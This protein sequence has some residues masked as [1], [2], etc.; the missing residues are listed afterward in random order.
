MR[1]L[2]RLQPPHAARVSGEQ[3][4]AFVQA[5]RLNDRLRRRHPGRERGGQ[6]RLETD[7]L[8]ELAIC[9][10][11]RFGDER[12]FTGFGLKRNRLIGLQQG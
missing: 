7:G 11:Q 12:A 9:D 10:L 5:A 4:A 1:R 3:L 6:A 8:F 2:L